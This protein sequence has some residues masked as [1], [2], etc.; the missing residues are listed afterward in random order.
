MISEKYAASKQMK[1]M[2]AEVSAP[3]GR[4]ITKGTSRKKPRITIT[5]GTERMPLT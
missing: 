4:P 1:V 5:R 2:T 3:M